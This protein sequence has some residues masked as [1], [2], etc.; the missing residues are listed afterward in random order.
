MARRVEVISGKP[1][2]RAD[3][4]AVAFSELERLRLEALAGWHHPVPAP[5]P[6]ESL[7]PVWIDEHADIHAARS[8]VSLDTIVA[9]FKA[10][11]SAEEIA[12]GY[13]T[14]QLAEVEGVIAYYLRYR[15]VVDAY[16]A[17]RDAEAEELR[18]K[19]EA[20]QPSK[21]ALK[22]QIKERWSRRRDARASPAE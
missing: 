3:Q 14:L 1:L 17:R 22:A 16:L 4:L 8:R 21:A 2:P 19:I 5:F 9:L 18:K 20:A 15:D 6:L 12:S 10:A 11:A 13:D 7:A